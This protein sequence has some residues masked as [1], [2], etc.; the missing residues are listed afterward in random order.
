MQIIRR[1]I[2]GLLILTGLIL[3]MEA[4]YAIYSPA[5]SKRVSVIK[6]DVMSARQQNGVGTIMS[7]VAKIKDQDKKAR[8]EGRATGVPLDARRSFGLIMAGVLKDIGDSIFMPFNLLPSSGFKPIT[9]CLRNDIWEMENLKEAV[10]REMVKAYLI[11]DQYHGKRLEDH[12]KYLDAEIAR[13][14]KY[15]MY[16]TEEEVTP[17]ISASEYF[18]GMNMP[19]TPYGMKLP[20]AKMEP[21]IS[22]KTCMDNCEADCAKKYDRNACEAN[23]CRDKEGACKKGCEK[24]IM[25]QEECKERCDEVI[26]ACKDFCGYE[27]DSCYDRCERKC[28]GPPA[29]EWQGCPEGDFL[30]AINEVINSFQNLKTA[31]N[32]KKMIEWG[33]I[34]EMAET[35]GKRKGEEWIKK[36]QITVTIGGREGGTVQSLMRAGGT[37]RLAGQVIT[38]L[39]A[40]KHMIGPLTPLFSFEAMRTGSMDDAIVSMG[41][42]CAY[43][44][45]ETNT[46]RACTPAQ[47]IE[48]ARCKEAEQEAKYDGIECGRYRNFKEVR[49]YAAKIMAYRKEAEER[50]QEIERAE[51]VFKYHSQLN[52]ITE[53]NI[54]EIRSQLKHINTVIIFGYEGFGKEG[55][56]GLPTLYSQ[57]SSFDKKHCGGK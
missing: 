15:G 23:K 6:Q 22:E 3:R 14:K 28:E 24:V 30:P 55:G 1:S 11:L 52:T 26:D 31:F 12:Y 35:R 33:S 16:G 42:G 10:F 17:G 13:L 43:Y 9:N 56:T 39:T 40:L 8:E 27:E 21:E 25:G 49:Q 51:T 57:M 32:P 38:Q 20:P 7:M 34:L 5:I 48:N 47:I 37:K 44:Y 53:N 50:E 29:I 36:N 46:F 2:I 41:E 4:V 19:V 45:P 18:F 54:D